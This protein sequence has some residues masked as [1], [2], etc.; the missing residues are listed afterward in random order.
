LMI[1]RALASFPVSI[2]KGNGVSPSL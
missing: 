2:T 1:C